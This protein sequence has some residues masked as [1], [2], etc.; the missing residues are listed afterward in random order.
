M[1]IQMENMKAKLEV[2]TQMAEEGIKAQDI[3]QNILAS[4]KAKINEKGQFVFLV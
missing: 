3:I 1:F 2:K 4:G